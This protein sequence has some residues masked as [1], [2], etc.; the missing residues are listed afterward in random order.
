MPTFCG[1][2][3]N[4]VDPDQTPN[5]HGGLGSGSPLLFARNLNKN[6]QKK[7]HSK[8]GYEL[9]QKI[10]MGNSLRHVWVNIKYVYK[11]VI[12]GTQFHETLRTICYEYNMIYLFYV[13]MIIVCPS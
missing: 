5:D 8:G 6:T 12:F 3:V 11:R 4:S 1:T 2:L 7:Q 9:V 10:M 13:Q